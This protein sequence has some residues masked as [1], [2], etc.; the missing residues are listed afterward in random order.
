MDVKKNAL[1]EDM[2][3]RFYSVSPELAPATTMNIQWR[4]LYK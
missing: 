4:D 2:Y 1:N 3:D